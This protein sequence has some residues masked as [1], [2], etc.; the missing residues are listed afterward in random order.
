MSAAAANEAAVAA[1]SAAAAAAAPVSVPTPQNLIHPGETEI[2]SLLVSI[3]VI[4]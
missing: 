4:M 1:A 3:K 2:P